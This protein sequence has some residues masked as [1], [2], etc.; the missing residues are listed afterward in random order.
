MSKQEQIYHSSIFKHFVNRKKKFVLLLTSF[1]CFYYF[2]LP[3]LTSF[4]P[5][6]TSMNIHSN[7]SFIW[8]FALSQIVMT[9]TICHLYS[10][11]AKFFDKTAQE[12]I[13]SFE[14]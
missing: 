7:V 6:L 11:R 12:I 5:K 8:I 10:Y 13:K 9:W 3:V 4:F 2:S 1:F 14:D